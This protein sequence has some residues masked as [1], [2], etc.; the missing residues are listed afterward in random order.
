[1]GNSNLE[2]GFALNMLSALIHSAHSYSAMRQVATTDTPEVRPSGSSRTTER[3]S[4]N[5]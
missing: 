2:V 4:Q 1:M 5:S 3:S